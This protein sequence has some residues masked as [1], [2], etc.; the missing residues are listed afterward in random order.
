MPKVKIPRKSVAIDMTPMVDMAFLLVTFFILTAAFKPDEPVTVSKPVSITDSL[1][2]PINR[3]EVTV[4]EDGRVFFDMS[5][6]DNRASLIKHM[7]TEYNVQFDSMEVY[8]F[9]LLGAFGEPMASMKAFLDM[10]PEQRKAIQQPG[11]PV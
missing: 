3:I 7:G 11:I 9:S 6:K 1:K 4:S 2:E 10:T 8:N 5:N